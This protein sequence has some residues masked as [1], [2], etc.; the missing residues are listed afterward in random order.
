MAPTRASTL[1]RILLVAAALAAG[2]AA[3][4]V[5]TDAG[6][7]GIAAAHAGDR[8]TY[9]VTTLDGPAEVP[10]QGT[11]VASELERGLPHLVADAAGAWHLAQE[12]TE[13]HDL[14]GRGAIVLRHQVAG[15]LTVASTQE[16]H[17]GGSATTTAIAPNNLTA[18]DSVKAT[19]WTW[20]TAY[21]GQA[22]CGHASSL[23]G[24]SVPADA[25]ATVAGACDGGATFHPLG[26]TTG[27]L[28]V[29]GNGPTKLWMSPAAPVPVRVEQ[30]L[31][32]NRTRTLALTLAGFTPGALDEPAVPALPAPLPPLEVA[33]GDRPADGLDTGFPLAD[34]LTLAHGSGALAAFE[35]SHPGAYLRKATFRERLDDL[36]PNRERSLQ[37]TLEST[38][39]H[40]AAAVRV[41]RTWS[42]PAMDDGVEALVRSLPLKP[43]DDVAD[44]KA[45]PGPY[46]P[47]APTTW[48]TVA[49]AL[50]RW[51]ALG[52]VGENAWGFEAACAGAGCPTAQAR[53]LVGHD[54]VYRTS[55][56]V[57]VDSVVMDRRTA[58]LAAFSADGTAWREAARFEERK[59]TGL[60][61]LALG[62][63]APAHDAP[64]AAASVPALPLGLAATAGLAL[65]LA[66]LPAK[67]LVSLWHRPA[68]AHPLRT[69]IKQLLEA[70]PG[71]HHQEILR[72]LGKG[73]SVVSHHLRTLEREG[74][75]VARQG[76]RYRVYFLP[77][78]PAPAHAGLAK[79]EL[80][81][82]ILDA[83][84]E[85]ATGKQ[86]ADRLGVAPSSVAFHVRR[87]QDAGLVVGHRV[88]REVVLRRAPA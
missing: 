18:A 77:H 11:W 20:W 59:E 29:L 60:G 54:D 72:R 71:L 5:H 37:W 30:P 1:A 57:T 2:T 48:P 4:Y 47:A 19:Q 73:N 43:T 66:L 80:A 58:D 76:P 50:A 28:L 13:R 42:S 27:G 41:S 56:V 81:A 26:R 49:S 82:R 38:D 21:G 44:L 40:A 23:Q 14:K 88:G 78:N 61:P 3:A 74:R 25:D 16:W 70:E 39:G 75:I 69:Q 62:D 32:W 12:V 63:T 51:H 33:S 65:L 7:F 64:L 15:P 31:P 9:N 46:P 83:L 79:S 85:P 67:L 22:P 35:Q 68:K 45:S 53:T 84:Q 34:A 52:G 8:W 86:L 6:R 87:F 36:A 55:Q 10:D 17:N 24:A